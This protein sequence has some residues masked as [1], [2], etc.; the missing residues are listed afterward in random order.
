M[1]IP[2]EVPKSYANITIVVSSVG[3]STDLL[4]VL[5]FILLQVC[6]ICLTNPKDMAFACG[7]QVSYS[8]PFPGF[9]ILLC[10]FRVIMYILASFFFMS[11]HAVIVENTSVHVPFAGHKSK[12]E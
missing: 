4:P 1:I 2:S 3:L 10:Y 9:H 12:P 11:R 8:N 6:P 7:H 5:Y